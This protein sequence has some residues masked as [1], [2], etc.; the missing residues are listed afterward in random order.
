[1]VR[2]IVEAI[3]GWGTQYD[4]LLEIGPGPGVLTEK[5][6]ERSRRL[7]VIEIDPQWVAHLQRRFPGLKI[8]QGDAL[9]IDWLDVVPSPFGI[10]GNLAYDIA[11]G[12]VWK[13]LQYRTHI[14]EAVLMMQ[15]EVARRLATIGER[16]TGW[17]SVLLHIWY[18][19]EKVVDV[20]PEAFDP[21]PKVWGTVLRMERRA[22]PLCAVSLERAKQLL[23]RLFAGRRKQL[24]TL[25][26]PFPAL[27]EH[28]E[29][30]PL[31]RLRPEQLSLD[32]WCT[33]LTRWE[34]EQAG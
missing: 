27:R 23:T 20:P 10:T 26:K 1:M 34:N 32:Q 3:R 5:L 28:P 29:I 33:L 13:M 25:L 21:P 16:Q 6:W 31:L 19:V 11:N 2:Q 12:V 24:G 15:R 22:Q 30:M 17:L 4:W 8:V 7:A 18:R 9:Q 14:P